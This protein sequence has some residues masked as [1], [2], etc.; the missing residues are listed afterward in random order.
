MQNSNNT[1]A[2]I[3]HLLMAEAINEP[4]SV[5]LWSNH[6]TRKVLPYSLYWHGRK[7]TVTTVGFHHT[8]RDGR[9]LMHMFSVSDGNTFFKLSLDS[10]TLTWKLVEVESS[11][12]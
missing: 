9:T 12:V 6:A 8:Y 7:Y 11:E 3:H 2:R 5:T 4:V 1:I 10:E